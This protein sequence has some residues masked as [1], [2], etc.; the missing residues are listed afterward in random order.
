M[1][2]S[3]FVAED[4]PR[5]RDGLREHLERTGQYQ[6]CG[7]AAD[8]EMALPAIL[9][10]K[11]DI[12]ITDVKM[13]FMDGLALAGAV[14]RALPRTKVL[15]ISGYDEFEFAKQAISI[16]VDEYLLKPVTAQAL[17]EALGKIG[18]QIEE[19]RNAL[20]RSGHEQHRERQEML[21]LRDGFFDELLSGA[22]DA[23]AAL[24][25]AERFGLT[26]PAKCYLVAEMELHYEH[27]VPEA[28]LRL[29][30]L[31]DALLEG[32]GDLLWCLRGS[33]RAVLIAK[34]DAPEALENTLYEAVLV[35][36]D[37]LARVLQVGSATFIG[38]PVQR[39]AA[40]HASYNEAHALLRRF[41]PLPE[42]SVISYEDYARDYLQYLAA[43]AEEPL[44]RRLRY[45][46]MADV[47]PILDTAFGNAGEVA[48]SLHAYSRFSEMLLAVAR[49]VNE[50]DGSAME[51]FP[52]LTDPNLLRLDARQARERAK[53]MLLRFLSWRQ[54]A[55]GALKYGDALARAKEYI[56]EHYANSDISLNTVAAY[57]GF[58]PNHF[59]T[60]FSQNTGETFIAFLTRTRLEH[61]RQLLLT[62]ALPSAEVAVQTGYGDTNY[63][64]FLFKK[65]YGMSP[66]EFRG[67]KDNQA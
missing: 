49:I 45:A 55:A 5:V 4:E 47:E 62:T 14:K 66:R 52:E 36:R 18:A 58:S 20:S 46:A 11:P 24:R 57:I 65:A 40:I 61:A 41:P 43:S 3:V 25:Q 8:G 32:R 42:G 34:G 30:P 39:I 1:S 51:L 16:G 38:V 23:P 44:A 15:I 33:D 22:L 64:R 19:E 48:S 28:A 53:G 60:I 63:F 13:P 50:T 27:A 7:E 17:L 56:Q 59:S 2:Y 54:G 37:E 12:V 10:L 31:A 21:R 29:R 9:E 6:L 35:V 26:L 67:P